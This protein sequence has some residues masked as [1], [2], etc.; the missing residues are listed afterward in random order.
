[1][2]TNNFFEILKT[3]KQNVKANKA[4]DDIINRL[5]HELDFLEKE[6]KTKEPDSSLV[7]GTLLEIKEI[8]REHDYEVSKF[9]ISRDTA[10]DFGMLRHIKNY[11]RIDFPSIVD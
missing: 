3:I 2:E 11:V 7:E 8:L 4:P 9:G 10:S 6:L 1:M 5:M